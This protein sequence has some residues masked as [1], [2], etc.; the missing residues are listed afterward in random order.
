M[1]LSKP[2]NNEGVVIDTSF[3]TL[4]LSHTKEC[5]ELLQ[6]LY[7]RG[8]V[9]VMPQIVKCE[10]LRT[11]MDISTYKVIDKLLHGI[12][13]TV[14]IDGDQLRSACTLHNLFYWIPETKSKMQGRSI[15]NDLLVGA[16][17]ADLE[18]EIQ[19]S[20]YILTED[21][22]FMSPYFIEEEKFGLVDNKGLTKRYVHLMRV[23]WRKIEEDWKE[24]NSIP[25]M[26]LR[27]TTQK[28]IDAFN[29]S[30]IVSRFVGK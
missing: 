12:F 9:L 28:L 21:N 7:D 15:F 10:I 26:Y 24:Y 25:Q 29:K 17:A 14:D 20:C 16:L 6:E 5:V 11:S 1:L 2:Q 3:F 27:S 13:D 8:V 19:Q 23:D 22:D 30:G 18:K 4:C